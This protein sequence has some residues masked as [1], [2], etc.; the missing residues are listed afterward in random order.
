MKTAS[1]Q[2]KAAFRST[3]SHIRERLLSD[4]AQATDQRY[5]LKAKDRSKLHL[6]H[7]DRAS[8]A[9]LRSWLDDPVRPHKKG[10]ENL[11]IL[12][13]ERAYTLT[14]RLVILMQLEARGLRGMKLISSGLEKSAFRDYQDFFAALTQD[15]DR[16][17]RFLLQQ[18]WDE[19]AVELPALFAYDEV[20]ECIPIPGPTLIWLLDASCKP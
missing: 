2:T 19:L 12:I 4:L 7:A 17:Y 15:D 6:S 9:L 14:N 11:G 16:G 5:S 1:D 8:Y 18:V 10:D 3:V 13:K 20:L